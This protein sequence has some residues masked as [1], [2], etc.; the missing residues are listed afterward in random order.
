[1]LKVVPRTA[2]PD[3]L[4][5]LPAEAPTARSAMIGRFELHIH[6]SLEAARESWLAVEPHAA[7]TPFQS[8]AWAN[9]WTGADRSR[10]AAE[11]LIVTGSERGRPRFVLPFAVEQHRGARRLVWL[12]Q[13]LADY[14]G[15]L[16]MPR[17]LAA[18]TRQ[19]VEDF[20]DRLYRRAPVFDYAYLSKQPERLGDI[21]NPFA[22]CAAVPFTCAAH[23][24]RL[25]GSFDEFLRATRSAKTL[26]SL[27]SKEKKLA[28]RGEVAF[29]C[30][31]DPQEQ[32]DFINLLLGWKTSQLE[33][34]GDRVP[35]RLPE[36]RDFF[37]RLARLSDPAGS[38]RLYALKL[39]AVP[40]AL[41]LCLVG[42]GR[43]I[44]YVPAYASGEIARLSPG[45]IMLNA[46][47]RR[48]IEEGLQV[49]DFANG[50]EGYKTQWIDRTEQLYVTVKPFSVTGQVAAM[51]DRLELSAIRA[52]K[53]DERFMSGAR[54]LMR[55]AR[56]WHG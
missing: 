22:R 40:I 41:A 25:V 45:A 47:I 16:M 20:L 36:A 23:H 35:F 53:S 3:G 13:K 27:R 15:P 18:L 48:S 8:Y 1:M 56:T 33:A 10:G 28:R 54:G 30:V 38:V 4:R 31:T 29:D 52:V 7:A 34:R 37:Q 2:T 51:I 26:S 42:N 39:D 43:M 6:R 44:Y 5:W 46:L 19:D 49:F 9:A 32:S 17:D 55:M 21:E 50:D 24:A 11:P 14:A 12:G